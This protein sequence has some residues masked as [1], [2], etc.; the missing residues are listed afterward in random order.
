MVLPA[1]GGS[2]VK[3]RALDHAKLARSLGSQVRGRVSAKSGYFGALE[4]AADVRRR[5]KSP[6]SGGRATDP[7]WTAKRLIPMRPDTLTR[8]QELA[9]EVSRCLMYR[10]EPLQL[11]AILIECHLEQPGRKQRTQKSLRGLAKFRGKGAWEGSLDE[12]R[13]SRLDPAVAPGDVSCL[14]LVRDLAGSVTGP[15][16]LSTSFGKPARA[17]QDSYGKPKRS[18]RGR[19][20]RQTRGSA[21]PFPDR[22]SFRRS[23]PVLDPPVSA[24]VIRARKD[25]S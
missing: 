4:L 23:M 3:R 11:A 24:T 13:R 6:A 8:L 10:V 7:G 1:N 5:F 17:S 15:S 16:D 2:K 14:D 25:R 21:K 9:N 19:E 12:L 18:R 22:S 20:S